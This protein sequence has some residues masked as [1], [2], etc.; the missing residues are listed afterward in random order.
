ML[1]VAWALVMG[2]SYNIVTHGRDALVAVFSEPP[3]PPPPPKQQ[4]KP[5]VKPATSSAAKGDPSPR[6]LRNQATPVFAPKPPPLVLPPPIVTATQPALGDAAQTGASNL[7]GPGQGAGGVGNG[8]GGG[9][10]GGDGEGDGGAVVGPRQIRGKL[11]M[12]D[13]P[14]GLLD[15]G[16]EARVGVRYSVNIDGSV[17]NCRADQPSGI[18]VLDA[19]ACRLIEQRFRYKPA[20][21][22][23]GNP[24]RA[25][26]VEAHYWY[27]REDGETP[28]G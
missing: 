16:E 26:V 2:L 24:V 12:R 15:P 6:N 14:D 5:A 23:A 1:L 7:A 9:G 17:S 4:P 21:D 8:N 27:M 22:R 25:T 18:A 10:N 13:L 19:L 3:P 11:S 28:G 20:R